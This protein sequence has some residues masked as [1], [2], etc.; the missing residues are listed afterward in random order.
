[1][2]SN[3]KDMN[4][5]SHVHIIHWLTKIMTREHSY[6]P[7]FNSIFLICLIPLTLLYTLILYTCFCITKIHILESFP[8]LR[9]V[10]WKEP[11]DE[12]LFIS[13]SRNERWK[14]LRSYWDVC[15]MQKWKQRFTLYISHGIR[16]QINKL[17]LL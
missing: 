4:K 3:T 13:N 10:L 14:L 1:M 12:T 5:P 6:Y 8:L 17:I 11:Y 9:Y 16:L 2:C 15:W 7:I